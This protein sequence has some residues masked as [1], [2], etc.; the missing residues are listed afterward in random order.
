MQVSIVPEFSLSS[1]PLKG[2][3]AGYDLSLPLCFQDEDWNAF[4]VF[5]LHFQKLG[6]IACLFL[7]LDFNLSCTELLKTVNY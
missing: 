4:V 6:A 3:F 1:I 2:S 7:F 5:I